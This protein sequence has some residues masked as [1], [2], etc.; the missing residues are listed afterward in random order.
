MYIR[1]VQWY[2]LQCDAADADDVAGVANYNM[3]QHNIDGIM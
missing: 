3:L 1:F 2:Q